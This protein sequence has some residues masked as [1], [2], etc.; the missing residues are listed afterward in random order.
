V[1]RLNAASLAGWPFSGGRGAL[2]DEVSAWSC[3]LAPGERLGRAGA[4]RGDDRRA[5]GRAVVEA[6]V[7]AVIVVRVGPEHALPAEVEAVAVGVVGPVIVVGVE[8]IGAWTR[9]SV[10]CRTGAAGD[11]PGGS[12]AGRLR[13][14]T[15]RRLARP[16]WLRTGGR[17]MAR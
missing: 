11:R 8:R 10:P 5:N 3:G 6:V 17:A 13:P 2:P 14:S 12:P 7:I 9:T 16:A 1:R 4:T 15:E